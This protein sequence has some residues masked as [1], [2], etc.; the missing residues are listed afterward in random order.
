M[1]K[2]FTKG[3]VCNFRATNVTERN[4]KNNDLFPE[5]YLPLVCQTDL[6]INSSLVVPMLPC[7][8]G[9]DALH[10]SGENQPRNVL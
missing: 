7:Y 1:T 9:Q 2:H 4:G 5:H 6:P 10:F 3:K 8:A